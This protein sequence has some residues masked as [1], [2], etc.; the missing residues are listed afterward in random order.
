MRRHR[1]SFSWQRHLAECRRRAGV[2]IARRRP[3]VVLLRAETVAVLED[4]W[5]YVPWFWL[6]RDAAWGLDEDGNEP[7][8][9][10]EGW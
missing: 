3:S 4:V 8:E 1:R 2:R 10:G 5:G 7:S 6:K 9:W